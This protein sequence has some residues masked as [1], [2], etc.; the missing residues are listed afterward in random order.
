MLLKILAGPTRERAAIAL[1]EFL[2]IPHIPT[3]G[4][5][6]LEVAAGLSKEPD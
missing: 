4:Y 6:R 5:E 2:G 1:D 3:E